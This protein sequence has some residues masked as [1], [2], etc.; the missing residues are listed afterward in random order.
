MFPAPTG[1]IK[2]VFPCFCIGP[3]IKLFVEP[4]ETDAPADNA[5]MFVD[6]VKILP[7]TNRRLEIDGDVPETVRGACSV[8]LVPFMINS[9]RGPVTVAAGETNTS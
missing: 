4:P 1:K 8:T 6:D 9:N 3:E 5:R 2:S 7:L